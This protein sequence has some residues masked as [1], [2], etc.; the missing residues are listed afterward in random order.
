MLYIL[1]KKSELYWHHFYSTILI[2]KNVYII[3]Y[4]TLNK[5]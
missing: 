1:K 3:L 5:N 2:K 4:D